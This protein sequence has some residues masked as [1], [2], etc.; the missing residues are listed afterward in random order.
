MDTHLLV[1]R[2]RS[3]AN[4][5]VKYEGHFGGEKNDC[6]RSSSVSQTKPVYI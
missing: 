2:S 6:F 1:S 3:S 4:F 5:K